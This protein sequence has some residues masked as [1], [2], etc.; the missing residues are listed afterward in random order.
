MSDDTID[1]CPYCGSSSTTMNAPGGGGR[2]EDAD[3]YRCAS[4]YRTF[5][6]H[7]TRDRGTGGG[8]RNDSAA[9]TLE[10]MGP[11]EV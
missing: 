3:R 4:C 6:E 5:D 1:A 11:D 10:Q 2:D 7:D 9:A 8:I